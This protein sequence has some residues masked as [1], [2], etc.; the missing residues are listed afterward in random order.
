LR[1]SSR[2][3][4]AA[5]AAAR[6]RSNNFALGLERGFDAAVGPFAP[7]KKKRFLSF[8]LLWLSCRRATWP[9]PVEGF[10]SWALSRGVDGFLRFQTCESNPSLIESGAFAILYPDADQRSL[11]ESA[12]AFGMTLLSF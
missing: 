10:A 5:A 7:P 2:C 3:A 4:L 6:F 11:A 9:A 8:R 1:F 12:S